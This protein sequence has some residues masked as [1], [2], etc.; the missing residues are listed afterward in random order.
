MYIYDQ[1]EA[2]TG[3]EWIIT[4][5]SLL[6]CAAHCVPLEYFP[7]S[8]DRRMRLIPEGKRMACNDFSGSL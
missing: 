1:D 2:L 3:E 8:T 7:L 5:G 4:L 6:E